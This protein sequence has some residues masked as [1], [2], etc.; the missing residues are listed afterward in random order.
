MFGDLGSANVSDQRMLR[1]FES[2]DAPT[3]RM[4]ENNNLMNIDSKSFDDEQMI[5]KH[6]ESIM[7][8]LTNNISISNQFDL[9]KSPENNE[10]KSALSMLPAL[11]Q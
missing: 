3:L 5:R 1:G 11:T 6:Q 2:K 10:K 8:R 7:S 9:L 4:P